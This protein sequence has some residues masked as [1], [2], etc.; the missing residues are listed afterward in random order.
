M[1]IVTEVNDDR[2]LVSIDGVKALK[3]YGE[4][5]GKSVN[6]LRGTNL[7]VES[8]ITLEKDLLSN[9]STR[10]IIIEFIPEEIISP[11]LL[12]KPF[13]IITEYGSFVLTET[14]L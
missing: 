11:Q 7:L 3:K 6:D 1:G 5:I 10:H 2:N 14:V 8:M 13:P 4:W 9:I 12:S